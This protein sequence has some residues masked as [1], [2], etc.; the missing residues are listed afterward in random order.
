MRD[1]LRHPDVRNDREA[2]TDEVRRLM[3]KRAQR[4]E[5]AGRSRSGDLGHEL[6]SDVAA[7]ERFRNNEGT[8]F[9]DL[10]AERREL[11]AEE[12]ATVAARLA[13]LGY[14]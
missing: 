14:L 7:P 9:G 13:D 8:D 6:R 11:S 5:P 12:E 2:H 4:R 10:G 3:G 1:L